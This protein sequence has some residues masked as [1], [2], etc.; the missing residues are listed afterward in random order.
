MIKLPSYFTGFSSRADG[1]AGLRFATQEL[2]AEDFVE[3]KKHHNAFGWLLF[4][5]NT[6]EEGNIPEENAEEEGITDSERLRRRMFV[7][8]KHP[9]GKRCE[10]DF[11]LWRTQQLETIGEKYLSKLE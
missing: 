4:K 7:Y 1:S 2:Q 10:G 11:R 9:K 8:W 5:E 6:F 3:L